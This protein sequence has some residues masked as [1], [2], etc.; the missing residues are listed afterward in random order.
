MVVRVH[1]GGQNS[2]VAQWRSVRLLIGWLLVQVQPREPFFW[3]CSRV[4]K[5][6]CLLSKRM[7]MLREFESLRFHLMCAICKIADSTST[8]YFVPC[9]VWVNHNGR[10]AEL[11]DATDLKSVAGNSVRVQV[12]PSPLWQ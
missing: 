7:K 3:N 8:K 6:T 10:V 11:A 1:S 12:P 4:A 9:G 2:L 5:G